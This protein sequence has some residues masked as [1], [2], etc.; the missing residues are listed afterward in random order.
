MLGFLQG[1]LVATGEFQSYREFDMNTG[2]TLRSGDQFGQAVTRYADMDGDG[3]VDFVVGAPGDDAS[4]SENL[5]DTGAIY[6]VYIE[7]IKFHEIPID[8]TLFYVLISVVPGCCLLIC[9]AACI[10]FCY[11]FRHKED[12]V[13][14]LAKEAGLGSVKL[15]ESSRS[16]RASGKT[17][18]KVLAG[19]GDPEN[20]EVA[21]DEAKESEPGGESINLSTS[22]KSRSSSKKSSSKK[23]SALVYHRQK[24]LVQNYSKNIDDFDEDERVDEYF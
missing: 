13:E 11:V 8:L 22:A 16:V 24:S 12:E 20:P 1:A 6:L 23:S 17:S 3:I 18:T 5:T 10:A 19:D 21:L 14:K 7:R 15:G 9:V 2:P 4:L